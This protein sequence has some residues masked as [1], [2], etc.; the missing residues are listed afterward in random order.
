MP[1]TLL[2]RTPRP[3]IRSQVTAP[4]QINLLKMT[5]LLVTVPLLTERPQAMEPQMAVQPAMGPRM[6]P[7]VMVPQMDLLT[8]VQLM[9]LLM[10][11]PQMVHQM[12]ELPTEVLEMVPPTEV[13]V[14]DLLLTLLLKSQT[15]IRLTR[16][17]E[18][19][20]TSSTWMLSLTKTDS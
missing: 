14:M 11:E 4:N 10:M 16:S 8:T 7:Q 5:L 15:K 2:L 9:D 18:P 6:V 19:S 3:L 20:R 1:R 12:M 17:R 13:L